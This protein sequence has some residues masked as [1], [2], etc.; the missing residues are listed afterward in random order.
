MQTKK[1]ITLEE[2]NNLTEIS[3]NNNPV[4]NGIACPDCEAELYDSNP[5]MT[6]TSFPPKKKI[7]CNN[8][9]YSGFRN[10]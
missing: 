3:G 5:M 4:L 9:N 2:H 8:C 6:L 7:H 1:L 10:A